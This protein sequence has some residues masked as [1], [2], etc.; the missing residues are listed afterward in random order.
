MGFPRQEYWNGLL[1]PSLE[2]LPYPGVK[3]ESSALAGRFFTTESPGNPLITHFWRDWNWVGPCESPNC[4]EAV[5]QPLWPSLSSKWQVPTV[6]NQGK[7]N[8]EVTWC[9]I[10]RPRLIIRIRR[11]TTWDESKGV[12]TLLT[13]LSCQT[14]HLWPTYKNSHEVLWGRDT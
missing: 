8:Q 11:L 5:H 1:F 7:N 9:K 14:P 6:A 2:D 3:P 12:Q 13:P 10:K 4:L